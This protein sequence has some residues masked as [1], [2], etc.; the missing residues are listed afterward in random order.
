MGVL[1]GAHMAISSE[2]KVKAGDIREMFP[3]PE[4]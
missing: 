2:S 1:I 4:T 3:I